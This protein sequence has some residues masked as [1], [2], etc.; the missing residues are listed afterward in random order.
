MSLLLLL[1]SAAGGGGGGAITYG[2][3]GTQLHVTVATTTFN[4]P[5][6]ASVVADDLLVLHMVTNGATVTSPS[7][8]T[9][10]HNETALSNPKGGLWIK[11]ATGSE[12]GNLAVTTPS[13][14]GA[15]VIHSYKNV[16]TTTAQDAA[17]TTVSYASTDDTTIDIPA[18]TTVTANAWFV[19]VGASNSSSVTHTAPDNERH[20]FGAGRAG[21]M[22]DGIKA[23]AGSTG[24]KTITQSAGRSYWGAMMVLRPGGG[25]THFEGSV[26]LAG[27]GSLTFSDITPGAS[28]SFGPNGSGTLTYAPTVNVSGSVALSGP[29][30]LTF[31]ATPGASASLALSG[32]GSLTFATTPNPTGAAA[33]SGSGTLGFTTT[34]HLPQSLAFTGSGTLSAGGIPSTSASL[35]LSGSGTITFST[36]VNVTGSVTLSGAG[37]LTFAPIVNVSDSTSLSGSGSLAFGVL[38]GASGTNTLSGSGTL[39]FSAT[40]SPAAAL[41][42]SGSGTLTYATS[43]N[44]SGSVE[45]SGSGTLVPSSDIQG[46]ID[47]SGSGSLIFSTTLGVS[48]AAALTGSG[49]QTHSATP[50]ASG[51][52]ALTGSGIQTHDAIV[53]LA[54]AHPLAGTGT[55][56]L[57]GTPSPAAALELSGSG[58]LTAVSEGYDFTTSRPA[59]GNGALTFGSILFGTSY[60]H[61]AYG[62]GSLT[63]SGTPRPA[64]TLQLSGTGTLVFPRASLNGSGTLF[65]SGSV[66]LTVVAPAPVGTP[67]MGEESS[68]TN[69]TVPYPSGIV[70]GELLVAHITNSLASIIATPPSGW[71]L[72]TAHNNSTASSASQAVFHRRADGT[73]TGSVVFS[74]HASSTGRVTGVMSRWSSVNTTPFD[75]SGTTAASGGA[76]TFNANTITTVT[77]NATVLY[78]VGMNISSSTDFVA[79]SGVT[80]IGTGTTGVGRRQ[81]VGYEAKPTA[82]VSTTRQWTTGSGDATIKW[83]AITVALRPVPVSASR[84]IGLSGSGTLGFSVLTSTSATVQLAG[85]GTLDAAG[86]PGQADPLE[87]S[88]TGTL[89]V[90]GSTQE[91][92]N[93]AALSGSGT[94][95][96]VQTGLWLEAPADLLGEG[97]LSFSQ[98]GMTVAGAVELS[99]SGDIQIRFIRLSGS[100]TLTLS[101]TPEPTV[102]L[103]LSGTGSLTTGL[104]LQGTGTLTAVSGGVSV[105]GQT[106][107]SGSGQ[108]ALTGVVRFTGTT[109]LSGTGTLETIATIPPSELTET[110]WATSHITGGAATPANALGSTDA[111]FTSNALGSSWTSRFAMADPAGQPLHAGTS[112]LIKFRVRRSQSTATPTMAANLYENGVLRQTLTLSTSSVTSDTGQDIT[113]SFP[114][115]AI[116]YSGLV[117]IEVATTFA[118]T[119]NS[120]SA[121]QLDSIEWTATSTINNNYTGNVNLSGS[122][123]VAAIASAPSASG[124]ASL[125]GSGTIAFSTTPRPAQS[126][127]F[128]G[129]GTLAAQQIALGVSGSTALSGSGQ[130][131]FSRTVGLLGSVSLSGSGVLVTAGMQLGAIDLSGSGAL[132]L[133]GVPAPVQN[134]ALSGSGQWSSVQ[135]FVDVR[136]TRAL[137][138]A[139]TL[140]FATVYNNDTAVSLSGSGTLGIVG[141]MGMSFKLALTGNGKQKRL[142]KPI[143]YLVKVYKSEYD[144]VPSSTVTI[145]NIVHRTGDWFVVVI[146]CS[147]GDIQ[148]TPNSNMGSMIGYQR[149]GY[150]GGGDPA[151]ELW[152]V[153][154]TT[155]GTLGQITATRDAGDANFTHDIMVYHYRYTDTTSHSSNQG[156]FET[157]VWAPDV[158]TNNP[159]LQSRP[160]HDPDAPFGA[161]FIYLD[162]T[163]G[164]MYPPPAVDNNNSVGP[165]NTTYNPYVNWWNGYSGNYGWWP[166]A[167]YPIAMKRTGLAA[168]TGF[169]LNLT[170]ETKHWSAV[171][172]SL[173]V[174]YYGLFDNEGTG[175]LTLVQSGQSGK[176]AVQLSGSGTLALGPA[177]NV[178]PHPRALSGSGTLSLASPVTLQLSG[179]GT[180]VFQNITPLYGNEVKRDGEGT[181]ALTTGAVTVGPVAKALSGS[182]TLFPSF[183][184]PNLGQSLPLSGTGT[185]GLVGK[186]QWTDALALSGSGTLTRQQTAVTAGTT[187]FLSGAGTLTR[188]GAGVTV[189]GTMGLSGSGTLSIFSTTGSLDTLY[190]SSEGSLTTS[191][192]VEFSQ[193]LQFSGSGTLAI[194]VLPKFTDTLHLSGNGALG[195][196]GAVG[197]LLASLALS[198]S[199]QLSLFAGNSA[200]DTMVRAGVGTLTLSGRA[201]LNGAVALSGTGTQTRPSKP[202]FTNRV[203]LHSQPYLSLSGTVTKKI[204]L[205][206]LGGLSRPGTPALSRTWAQ[207]GYSALTITPKPTTTGQ[208]FT[209]GEGALAFSGKPATKG[210]VTRSGEGNLT[211]VIIAGT[212]GGFFPTGQGQLT[213]SGAIGV[214]DDLTLSGAGTNA[215]TGTPGFSVQLALSGDGEFSVAYDRSFSGTG[216]L[217]LIGTVG[218]ISISFQLTGSGTLA[219]Q[220]TPATSG[221]AALA[222]AGTLGI[223]GRT[224]VPFTGT[225]TLTF[226][227]AWGISGSVALTGSGALALSVLL[228]DMSGTVRASHYTGR[229]LP[230]GYAGQPGQP[231]ARHGRILPRPYSGKVFPSHWSGR[232]K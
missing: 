178:G 205:S 16:D 41:D 44:T 184:V 70:S 207:T 229:V 62:T 52:A 108:L 84:S 2:S 137:S 155:N 128:S 40:P 149:G 112:Q 231:E 66:P 177:L 174:P 36:V 45:L 67:T 114:S 69:V 109:N 33:L 68:A 176:G 46:S 160:I 151:I 86:N 190:L 65:V 202:H 91:V 117:E 28:A 5:Y 125:S 183:L 232:T 64:F 4:V 111:A 123:T 221:Q 63:L 58:T 31:A 23:T 170:G 85:S 47:L 13:T 225:G 154:A 189:L 139:G 60:T 187:A 57:A 25:G 39:T 37:T 42:L 93:P 24:V 107:L 22:Y 92:T 27:A 135:V 103:D 131:T 140:T 211:R 72:A 145:S 105:S 98:T 34:P 61:P 185:L 116:V 165:N 186:P 147:W 97:T 6:P 228:P 148:F 10:V 51:A 8:W 127:S 122:G 180:L 181:L 76:A 132:A 30:T 124:S 209:S 95:T 75:A 50:G 210:T 118:G 3:S 120:R 100:G 71:T 29:G 55:L 21:A 113:T 133:A 156:M 43:V 152:G 208:L 104:S 172:W 142:G 83:G 94:L 53:G 121:V 102:E 26:A 54:H 195:L 49:I 134:L 218:T 217:A 79:P 73:E 168:G 7:G 1:K 222:G 157:Y 138:G 175:Q 96:T 150:R 87:L 169:Y 216:T 9:V 48:G 164:N 126:I 18:I 173:R 224:V 17:A 115:S 212:I 203:F 223:F 90:S 146:T 141:K 130:L 220:A 153:R 200:S 158:T 206:G 82:G 196:S 12:S 56:A 226:I 81:W 144:A 99:G 32:S 38:A 214:S 194:G 201:N 15:A 159:Q 20:D 166:Y 14:T 219:R 110:L 101:G 213:A 129:A 199:G 19:Y 192:T 215:L 59:S 197:T 230:S 227:T 163:S 89:T 161:V 167:I 80:R 78:T 171:G 193:P 162:E 88:G 179:S 204:F 143:A 35:D 77:D 106:G 191:V 74:S 119:G 11:K 188:T 136:G 198:G 182:G